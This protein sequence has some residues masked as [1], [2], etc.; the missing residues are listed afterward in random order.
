MS[1]VQIVSL[2]RVRG[3]ANDHTLE[4]ITI[5]FPNIKHLDVTWCN[6]LTDAGLRHVSSLTSLESLRLNGVRNF[7]SAELQHSLC[8]LTNLRELSFDFCYQVDGLFY[9]SLSRLTKLRTLSLECC[10]QLTTPSV[11]ETF[12][13]FTNLTSLNISGCTGLTNRVLTIISHNMPNLTQLDISYL[14]SISGQ[15]VEYLVAQLTK[16]TLLEASGNGRSANLAPLRAAHQGDRLRIF[17]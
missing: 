3:F 8:H 9:G 17:V 16:L 12:Q 4:S 10:V 7:S 13:G 6:L 15:T 11:E 2:T 14:N 1:R 5:R